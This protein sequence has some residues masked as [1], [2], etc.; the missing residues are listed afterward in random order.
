[1]DINFNRFLKFCLEKHGL[2]KRAGKHF[3]EKCN[4]ID[5][6]GKSKAIIL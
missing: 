1:M 2:V 4:D 5:Y 3:W 6:H